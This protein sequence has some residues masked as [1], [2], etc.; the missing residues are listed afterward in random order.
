M[1]VS[2]TDEGRALRRPITDMG[3]ALEQ[4]SVRDLTPERTEAFTAF[5]YAIERSVRDHGRRTAGE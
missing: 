5:A 1:V 2:L 3:R 4:I